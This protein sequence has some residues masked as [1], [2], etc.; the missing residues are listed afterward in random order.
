M[1]VWTDVR[2]VKIVADVGVNYS[3]SATAID[4]AQEAIR[5]ID[6]NGFGDLPGDGCLRVVGHSVTF[7]ITDELEREGT[8]TVSLSVVDFDGTG[9]D[10]AWQSLVS[11]RLP[12]C[13]AIEGVVKIQEITATN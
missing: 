1:E 11:V 12:Q 13:A 4:L 2:T 6:A 5:L 7:D 10:N 3:P 8:C 9:G